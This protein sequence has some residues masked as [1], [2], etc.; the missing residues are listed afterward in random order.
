MPWELS[1]GMPIQAVFPRELDKITRSSAQIISYYETTFYM[2]NQLLR[3]SDWASMAHSVELRTP[4]ID[5][6]LFETV[7]LYAFQN[8]KSDLGMCAS[9]PLPAEV[10]RRSKTGFNVP[11]TSWLQEDNAKLHRRGLKPWQIEVGRHF[12]TIPMGY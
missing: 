5:R 10:L 7:S 6:H 8:N 9:P 1:D 12:N 3:D 4:F 2:R 11:V